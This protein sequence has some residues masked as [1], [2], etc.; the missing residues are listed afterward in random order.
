MD[1]HY[2]K[3][4]PQAFVAS[5]DGLKKL[6][7]LLQDRVGEVDI[8]ADCADDLSRGFET[9]EDLIAYE[10]TKPKEICSLY[11]SAHPEDYS[12][13]S[14]RIRFYSSFWLGV[15]IDITGSEDDVSILK[16]KTL[17]IIAGMRPWY[18]AM[19]HINFV[20]AISIGLWILMT[21]WIIPFVVDL[22][23]TFR[24]I[25]MSDYKG[26]DVSFHVYLRQVM[27]IS[28][29]LA[30]IFVSMYMLFFKRLYKFLFPRAFFM[31]GQGRSRFK[32]QQKI[33]WGVVIGFLVS[34]AAAFVTAI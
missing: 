3:E 31:I 30:L 15:L 19:S 34:L 21:F 2:S 5:P 28:T 4:L 27:P 23:M 32:F 17:D 25:P 26:K 14:A 13:R 18:D 11:L 6:V 33:R 22:V 16:E 12:K 1:V 9:V 10:N 20:I 29:P 8:R 24:G 7:E